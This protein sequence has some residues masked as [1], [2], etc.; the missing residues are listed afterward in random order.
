MAHDCT[1]LVQFQTMLSGSHVSAG[2]LLL[3]SFVEENVT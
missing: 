3:L 1:P 2:H